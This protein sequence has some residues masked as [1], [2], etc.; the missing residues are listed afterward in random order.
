MFGDPVTNPMG[1]KTTSLGTLVDSK[2][3]ISYGVVQRGTNIK[4]GVPIV[5]ISNI[6]GNI[7][8]RHPIVR[9]STNIASKYQ[10]T[11]LNGGELLISIR[12]TVGK[13]AIAPSDVKGWNVSRE[14][15]VIP[16]RQEVSKEY[17]HSLLLSHPI[18]GEITK[19]I[20]G[21]AQKGINLK[22]LSALKVCIPPWEKQ[23]DWS[24]FSRTLSGIRSK[25]VIE[26]QESED[27]FNSLLQR[28]FTGNL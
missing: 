11:T 25:I 15:A 10:R 2:R 6:V 13:V 23:Q 24:I 20:K 18:Q 28:A 8:V 14:I 22:N 12:G 26:I 4:N 21:I 9:T 19:D 17:I 1:W 7:F 16:L 27:L 5:R 3:G